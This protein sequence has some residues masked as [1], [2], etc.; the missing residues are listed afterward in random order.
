M[1]IPNPLDPSTVYHVC[2]FNKEVIQFK[3]DNGS[4]LH[5]YEFR[6]MEDLAKEVLD[7]PLLLFTTEDGV[8]RVTPIDK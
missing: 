3:N 1:N 6:L 7:A 5:G 4:S 2:V 8:P